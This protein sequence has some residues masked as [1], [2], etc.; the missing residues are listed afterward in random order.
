MRDREVG[1]IEITGASVTP[2]YYGRPDATAAA[3]H[4]GWLRTGDLGYLV[5][6]ELVVCGRIKDVIILGGR[7]VYPQD[8]ERAI[9]DVDGVRA[10]NVIAFGTAGRRGPRVARRR[11]RSARR[12]CIRTTCGARSPS[13]VRDVVGIPAEE[14]VLVHPGTLPKTSS[15]KL[16]RS[17]CRERYLERRPRVRRLHHRPGVAVVVVVGLGVARPSQQML[18][19]ARIASSS[20][21]SRQRPQSCVE[22]AAVELARGTRADRRDAA[23]GMRLAAEVPDHRAQLPLRVERDAVVDAE[24][25]CRRRASRQW[26]P[27]R[28]VLLIT[29]SNAAMRRNSSPC[30]SSNVK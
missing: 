13:A 30:S 1:E 3:F 14:V 4:D 8:V 27:L 21:R 26:P 9:A 29:M 12:R 6:G 19:A 25:A 10:G 20:K 24:D 18:D 15:G 2:G 23:A 22:R 16:Q 28:S 7:N 11:R 17:L 5:D